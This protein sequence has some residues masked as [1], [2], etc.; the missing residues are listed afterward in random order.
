MKIK[1]LFIYGYGFL[2]DFEIE[3]GS[4]LHV[5]YGKNEAGKST[6]LSFIETM[7]FGFPKRQQTELQ[8]E[9]KS[10]GSYGGQLKAR[11]DNHGLLSIERVRN[12]EP[13]ESII[14]LNDKRIGEEALQILLQSVDRPLYQQIFSARLEHLQ[15]MEKLN[16][17]DLNRFLLGTSLSGNLSLHKL[18]AEL[19]KK[20]TELYLPRGRKPIMNE[21][22]TELNALATD[23]KKS[24]SLKA[25][26]E[27]KADETEEISTKLSRLSEAKT[28]LHEELQFL[29]T[30]Q[31]IT[32]LYE[33]IQLYKL[34]LQELPFVE[35]FPEDG[36][37]RLEQLQTRVID[38][39]A[40]LRTVEQRITKL[41]EEKPIV[42]ED[43][44]AEADT[45]ELLRERSEVYRVKQEQL[46]LITEQI[47]HDEHAIQSFLE[48]LGPHWTLSKLL[49]ADVSLSEQEKLEQLTNDVMELTEQ[50]KD[51]EKKLTETREHFKLTEGREAQLKQTLLSEEEK[52]ELQTLVENH[53]EHRLEQEQKFI[54]KLL[55]QYDRQLADVQK[56][57]SLLIYSSLIVGT[58]IATVL[59]FLKGEAY[60]TFVALGVGGLAS[61]F[62]YKFER[63]KQTMRNQ[64]RQFKK[65]E[66]HRLEQITAQ[67][68]KGK[69]EVDTAKSKLHVDENRRKEWFVLKHNREQ[70]EMDY[71]RFSREYA[72][73]DQALHTKTEEA[74][75]WAQAHNYPTTLSITHWLALFQQVKDT[76]EQA[77]KLER[78]KTEQAQLE[79]WINDYERDVHAL[80]RTFQ[81]NDEES[82]TS[83]LLKLNRL[84]EEEKAKKTQLTERSLQ[85]EEKEK[86]FD[87]LKVKISQYKGEITGLLEVVQCETREAFLELGKAWAE[88][89]EIEEQM[90][91]IERQIQLHVSDPEKYKQMETM[92]KVDNVDATELLTQRTEHLHE[93]EQE[94]SEL[95]QRLAKLRVEMSAIEEGGEYDANLQKLELRK[96]EL[97]YDAEQ[98]ATYAIALHL[99]TKTK[100]R[101]REERLPKVV[102]IATRYF[103][104]MTNG[105]YHSISIPV[106]DNE[107]LVES[108]YGVRF[109]PK[110][111]SRGT[112]EQLYLSLRL[113]LTVAYPSSI[114]FPILLDDILVHFDR[115]RREAAFHVIREHSENH[116][117]LFFT[118]HERIAKK[119]QEEIIHLGEKSHLLF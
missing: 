65:E 72:T 78:A 77:R 49:T 57:N 12:R 51:L 62:F 104:K 8:Y 47:K 50:G 43:W 112:Q 41:G 36:V 13:E 89:Q 74:K 34:E 69:P 66:S 118:C 70:S 91:V 96:A 98:W 88:K 6:I 79:Q 84:L 86:Q 59:L 23:L 67:N 30:L 90:Q 9:P 29:K 102:K 109:S 82:V 115:E 56:N 24:E 25:D 37:A 111:L 76:K 60:L 73:L 87:A 116:Q 3:L 93:L 27:E 99:L 17:D 45:I 42:N 95:M 85:L 64:L 107:F 48:Q 32:P 14:L 113:A 68:D 19:K 97:R 22:L 46:L 39:E 7:L 53:D 103:S 4:S 15:E 75:Q 18:E 40:D 119:C 100:D 83:L 38:F 106:D 117:I 16:E 35:Q 1:K 80:C 2:K 108:E 21:A 101:F 11:L 54:H 31:A 110:E 63:H 71:E 28:E 20:Q 105:A 114:R 52:S 94:E 33:K 81:L 55:D 10:G 92:L 61:L 26:F 5:V 58:L 44:L